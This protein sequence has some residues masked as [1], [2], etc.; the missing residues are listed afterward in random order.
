[1]SERVPQ[2]RMEKSPRLHGLIDL[3]DPLRE[4]RRRAA[5]RYLVEA[6]DRGAPV[7]LSRLATAAGFGVTVDDVVRIEDEG[8]AAG[9]PPV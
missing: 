7:R 8:I 2:K 3:A 4:S 5:F 6:Q 1:M 9:W